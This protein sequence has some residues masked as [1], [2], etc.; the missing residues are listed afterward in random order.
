VGLLA[1]ILLMG[2]DKGEYWVHTCW[3]YFWW[4]ISWTKQ[5]QNWVLYWWSLI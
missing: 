2:L 3:L 4:F 5:H 1:G